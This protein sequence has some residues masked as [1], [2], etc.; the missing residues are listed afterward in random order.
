MTT[1]IALVL[2]LPRSGQARQPHEMLRE[3]RLGRGWS[4]NAMTRALI[5]AA[6]DDERKGVPEFGS[7][8][9]NWVRWERGEA[10]PDRGRTRPFFKPII[11]RAFGL[12]PDRI[13]PVQETV[14]V[15]TQIPDVVLPGEYR[16]GLS[17]RRD[18]VREAIGKLQAEL[19]YLNALLAVPPL[20][21]IAPEVVAQ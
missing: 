17:S 4:L 18:T 15:R 14:R 11:A 8:R 13:W 21:D 9:R 12:T 5:S 16:D 7:L 19:T 10:E 1:D 2:P 20:R 3:L 6:T